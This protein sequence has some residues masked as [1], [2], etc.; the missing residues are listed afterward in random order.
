MMIDTELSAFENAGSSVGGLILIVDD[1]EID[2]VTYRRYLESGSS[3]S[4]QIL[5]CD[6]AATALQLCAQDCPD[7]ILLDYLLPD[8]DGIE[9]LQDL[10]ELLEILPPVIMLTGQGNEEVAVEAMKQGA[11]D[12]LVKGHL[13]RQ[14]LLNSIAL[15]MAE[16]KL[17]S[18]L[19]QQHRQRELVSSIA[20]KISCAIDF[21][22]ILQFA[23]NGSR[24]LLGCDRALV[25]QLH[26]EA[27][28]T[29]VAESVASEWLAAIGNAIS[30]RC[31][32]GE[33]SAQIDKYLKGY[34]T[35]IANIETAD[36]TDCHIQMLRQFQVKAVLAVPILFRVPPAPEQR[37]W[38]LLIAHHC[39][40]VHEWTVDELNLLDE[41]SM[42]MA[43]GI[44][45]AD[46]VFELQQTLAQQ[47]I[48]EQQ[49][50]DRLIE[51]EQTNGRLSKTTRLLTARN[52]ELDEFSCVASHDLQAPL[53]GIANLAEWLVKDLE[54]QLPPENQQQLELI[55]SRVLQMNGLINGL[56]LYAR[57][58]RENIDAASINISQ[59]LIEVI[60]M[61]VVPIGFQ[62]NFAPDLPTI[63]TQSL[64]L[65]QVLANLIGNAIKYHDRE[66]GKIE[67]VVKVREAFLEFKII[68]DGSGIAP[69][70]QEK[71]FGI[72]QTLVGRG[73]LKGTGIGLAIV[74]K[75]V[76]SQG[77]LVSVESEQGKG[78][79]FLFTWPITP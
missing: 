76:E 73:D 47:Q 67:I 13:T 58:G 45:Q 32:Q 11:K 51:I 41:L 29:I 6:S 10:A 15:V 14:K 54:G 20:L 22:E 38:G 36:S 7:V 2:R 33:Q 12:Y 70:N 27:E 39:K 18:Q 8:S 35:V 46:L 21:P 53:R 48:I 62:V 72:F 19:S 61:L 24:T 17:Q 40:A 42:Q 71:I 68:D 3:L 74:K 44:Q 9:F 59:L 49:L 66:N 28:G 65:K 75:I 77:G 50:R 55:Q 78:S 31:L 26:P 5:D 52:Q 4:C 1:S 64:L 57:V 30:D 69:E 60:E 79:I 56:L 34:K 23:V 63:V 16:Q 37:V 25:Y 43:I